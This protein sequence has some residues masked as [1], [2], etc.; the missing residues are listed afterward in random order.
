MPYTLGDVTRAGANFSQTLEIHDLPEPVRTA[1]TQ[2]RWCKYV[3]TLYPVGVSL[4]G[5]L[6]GPDHREPARHE[7]TLHFVI[8]GK[9]AFTVRAATTEMTRL[10]DLAVAGDSGRP[11]D[12]S[13]SPPRDGA[14]SDSPSPHPY[15]N[16]QICIRCVLGN[17]C[18]ASRKK[19]H[20]RNEAERE[21]MRAE[22]ASRPCHF[23]PCSTP[24]CLFGHA[25][26][27]PSSSLL[28]SPS[29]A[30][31][32][33]TAASASMAASVPTRAAEAASA[34]A[35]DPAVEAE[36]CV[37][38]LLPGGCKKKAKCKRQHPSDAAEAAAMRAALAAR[39]CVRAQ[40]WPVPQV[41]CCYGHGGALAQQRRPLSLSPPPRS[42]RSPS[43]PPRSRRS[44]SPPP[45]SRRSP[46][47]S[48]SRT[49]LLHMPAKE[50]R[51]ALEACRDVAAL[52]EL[53]NSID[54]LVARPVGEARFNTVCAFVQRLAA[55]AD[56]DASPERARGLYNLCIACMDLDFNQA[57]AARN[58]GSNLADLLEATLKLVAVADVSPTQAATLVSMAMSR[59]R[60]SWNPAS[61]SRVMRALGALRQPGV[62]PW[63]AA[64]RDFMHS[65]KCD[66]AVLVSIALGAAQAGVKDEAVCETALQLLLERDRL[67]DLSSDDIADLAE[68]KARTRLGT[69]DLPRLAAALVARQPARSP[70][71]CMAVLR[72]AWAMA[73]CGKVDDVRELVDRDVGALSATQRTEDIAE[74]AVLL[75]AWI[76]AKS[77]SGGAVCPQWLD[78]LCHA[79]WVAPAL[80]QL[81]AR[82]RPGALR[83]V[84]E[85]VRAAGWLAEEGFVLGNGVEAPLLVVEPARGLAVAVCVVAR[86]ELVQGDGALNGV[87]RAKVDLLDAF[88]RAEW[89]SAEAW[90]RMPEPSRSQWVRALFAT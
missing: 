38:A 66:D 55:V 62:P 35:F 14:S 87:A 33:G 65:G 5:V 80:K 2:P 69:A 15:R 45:R 26:R 74:V 77:A 27:A 34:R 85:A 41:D 37:H 24:G 82:A 6:L 3:K 20:P 25:H 79:A 16:A 44:P 1:V 75:W 28:S 40:C 81:R 31:A 84:A 39:P 68:A 86:D 49:D 7:R 60:H 10:I 59:K 8:D 61:V 67:R 11:A 51:A 36:V 47:P 21:L 64:L 30:H 58:P 70:L 32:A 72:V 52:D 12:A 9:D 76:D 4:R 19:V 18:D 17:S 42:R 48:R 71:R 53:A 43:P 73:A 50:Q 88:C 23:N 90:A 22:L 57:G 46:S 29:S 63:Q 54:L 78:A 83:E 56:A 13:S 89:L